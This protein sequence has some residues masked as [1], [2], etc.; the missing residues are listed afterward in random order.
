MLNR[1][2]APGVAAS[3]KPNDR[4]DITKPGNVDAHD[5]AGPPLPDKPSI[6]VLPFA[7][8]Q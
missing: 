1:Q 2:D 6:A 8:R 4:G 5:H 3:P 7:M